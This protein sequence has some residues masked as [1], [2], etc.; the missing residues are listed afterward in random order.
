MMI[1]ENAKPA[2]LREGVSGG[3]AGQG[4][5]YM[6]QQQAS[7]LRYIKTTASYSEHIIRMTNDG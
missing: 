6:A 3:E 1:Y 2:R 7:S 4:W 5:K